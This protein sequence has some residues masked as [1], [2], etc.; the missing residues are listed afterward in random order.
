MSIEK[1]LFDIELVRNYPKANR[2]IS[3]SVRPYQIATD[4]EA[5]PPMKINE[6]AHTVFIS[7]YGLEFQVPAEY[8][9]GT[10][11]KIDINIPDF[12]NRKQQFVDY[13]RVDTPKKFNILA[14]VVKSE[15]VGKRGR[16]KLVLAQTVN[17]DE[18]DER[19]LK[20]FLQEGKGS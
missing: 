6:K 19:V 20:A 17:I 10:L 1:D 12:W 8:D 9:C 4:L 13:S 15:N 11:L 18:V 5:G 14:K 7:P 3:L 2:K 16:K